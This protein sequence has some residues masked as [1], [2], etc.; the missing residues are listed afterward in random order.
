MGHG[1][2]QLGVGVEGAPGVAAGTGTAAAGGIQ[3]A[4]GPAGSWGTE[5]RV[6]RDCTDPHGS[7]PRAALSLPSPPGHT[8]K[9]S[10]LSLPTVRKAFST[11]YLPKTFKGQQS[12]ARGD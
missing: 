8:G 6:L 9:T 5:E 2:E 11:W 3:E 4:P 10:Q 1:P 7:H 12:G